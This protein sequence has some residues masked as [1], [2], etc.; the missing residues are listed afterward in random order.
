M[1]F[2]RVSWSWFA[3]A[4]A[5]LV[6]PAA[7]LA[8]E[9]PANGA[10]EQADPGV[11]PPSS[12]HPV[13]PPAPGELPPIAAEFASGGEEPVFMFVQTARAGSF[14]P[15]PQGSSTDGVLVLEGVGP[16]TV[17]FSDR[18]HRI[19]GA[20]ES[21]VFLDAIGF[22]ESNPP[23][24]AIVLSQPES[25]SQDVLVAELLNPRYDA[26]AQSLSYDVVL[27]GA[28]DGAGGD[29]LAHWT[30]RA[31]TSLPAKFGHVSLF[32]DDC[33]DGPVLCYGIFQCAGKRCCRVGCGGV[34]RNVGYCWSW[35]SFSCNPCRDYSYL[36]SES[37]GPCDNN[38]PFCLRN[39]CST[40]RSCM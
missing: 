40:T 8:Q 13:T 21:G 16:E 2:V 29:G 5:I 4:F 33:P 23:N 14:Q 3:L 28:A 35:S 39:Q 26:A 6:L 19:A 32:I 10:A 7:A 9:P 37:G 36:C 27:L 38:P 25:E 22:E 15:A 34:G 30:G 24:A 1:Y 18:P 20:V 31:D 17:Y 11:E 12:H